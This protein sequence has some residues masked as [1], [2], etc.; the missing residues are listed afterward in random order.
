M[1]LVLKG[2]Q[3]DGEEAWKE[4]NKKLKIKKNLKKKK[5]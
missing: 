5:R 4:I 1:V 2:V 3:K